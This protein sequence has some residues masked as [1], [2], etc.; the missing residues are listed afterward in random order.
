ME[1]LLRLERARGI[2]YHARYIR[3]DAGVPQIRAVGDAQ[4]SDTV[5][6]R[7]EIVRRGRFE[8]VVVKR[9]RPGHHLQHERGIGH[10]T[11]QWTGVRGLVVVTDRHIGHP[12]VRGL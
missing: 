8:R 1:A 7:S 12:A 9:M 6:K 10:R 11:R 2:R 5:V 3:V 4:A